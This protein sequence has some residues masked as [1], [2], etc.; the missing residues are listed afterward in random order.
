M[1]RVPSV[2]AAYSPGAVGMSG[3]R[4]VR[5]LLL[6]SLSHLIINGVALD[7]GYSAASV[8]ERIYSSDEGL[9][10]DPM[11]GILLY[12]AAPDAEGTLG[13]LVSLAEPERLGRIL[14]QALERARICASDPMCA[15]HVPNEHDPSLHGAACHACL[16]LPETSC[17]CGNRYLDRSVL[18]VTLAE[19]ELGYFDAP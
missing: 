14:D 6:H 12:T 15:E 10:A 13:G 7:C 19:G 17:E 9:E 5:F 1:S 11:A 2:S 8:R 4:S 3:A 18:Q 16:F